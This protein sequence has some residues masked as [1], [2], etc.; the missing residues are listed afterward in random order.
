M[1]ARDVS[2]PKGLPA[3]SYTSLE[4]A[5]FHFAAMTSKAASQE[6]G[7]KS[8]S[9]ANWPFLFRSRGWMSR[10]LPYLMLIEVKKATGMAQPP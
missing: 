5:S 2:S 9:S 7:S 3:L 1:P 4:M 6:T 8:P 10:S